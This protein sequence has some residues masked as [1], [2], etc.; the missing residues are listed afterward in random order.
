MW[1]P[2]WFVILEVPGVAGCLG[3]HCFCGERYGRILYL[4]AAAL[5][6]C[7]NAGQR[8][9]CRPT[10]HGVHL[11]ATK[12]DVLHWVLRT[13]KSGRILT[14]IG[15]LTVGPYT[16]TTIGIHLSAAWWTAILCIF[17]E[18]LGW[19]ARLKQLKEGRPQSLF[20]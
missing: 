20:Q 13:G 12:V 8:Y 17:I 14:R 10:A 3:G 7:L 18:L 1:Q 9:S 19:D 2:W 5:P 11:H 4:G 6:D 15:V 16:K